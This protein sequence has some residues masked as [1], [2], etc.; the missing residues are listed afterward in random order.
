MA[1]SSFVGADILHFTHIDHMHHFNSIRWDSEAL[2][3][4]G[5]HIGRVQC[6]ITRRSCIDDA[7]FKSSW[8]IL[9]IVSRAALSD[10]SVASTATALSLRSCVPTSA[11]SSN[12]DP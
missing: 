9:L 5:A 7:I 10:S 6:L 2:E 8:R 3:F 1:T 11:H 12:S 4:H